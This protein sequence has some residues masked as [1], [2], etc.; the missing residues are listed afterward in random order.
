VKVRQVPPNVLAAVS[1]LLTP[2]CADAT[3]TTIVAAL[4]AHGAGPAADPAA[5]RLLSLREAGHALG[6]SAHTAR[7]RVADGTLKAVRIGGVFRIPVTEIDA[8]VAAT[9]PEVEA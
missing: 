4:Q 3:P 6:F 2:Y 1:A 7:R 5:R 8:L 9:P